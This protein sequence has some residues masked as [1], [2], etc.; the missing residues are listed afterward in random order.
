MSRRALLCTG[1]VTAVVLPLTGCALESGATATAAGDDADLV[2]AA[3]SDEA[4]F[5]VTCTSI[6]ERNRR[7][8]KQLDVV[9]AGQEAHIDALMELLEAPSAPSPTRKPGQ[10]PASVSRTAARLHDKRMA[11]SQAAQAGA[12]AQLFASMAASHAVTAQYWRTR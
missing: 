1:A 8:A 5:A 9:I 4:D 6:R 12:L 7:L 3:L 10:S 2:Q 11:D